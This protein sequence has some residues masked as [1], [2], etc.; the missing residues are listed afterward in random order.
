MFIV[1]KYDYLIVGFGLFVVTFAYKAHHVCK[2]GR[3]IG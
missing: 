3:V 2:S 1:V